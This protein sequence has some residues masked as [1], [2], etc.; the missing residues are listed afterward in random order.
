MKGN[1]LHHLQALRGIAA[2]LVVLDHALDSLVRYGGLSS[3]FSPLFWD[4]AT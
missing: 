3:E 2:S 1:R 4:C